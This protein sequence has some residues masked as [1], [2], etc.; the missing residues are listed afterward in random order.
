[1]SQLAKQQ[2]GRLKPV[3]LTVAEGL[4]FGL[5]KN[6]SDPCPESFLAESSR[7]GVG[8]RATCYRAGKC[9]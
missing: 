2:P 9:R 5:M 4:P 1:M 8:K 3:M 6:T 7:S